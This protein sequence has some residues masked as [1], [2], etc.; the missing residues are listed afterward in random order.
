MELLIRIVDK[1]NPTSAE[2]DSKCM[3][4][5]DVIAI[6]PGGSDWGVQEILNPEWRIIRVPGLSQAEIDALLAPELPPTLDEEYP[7]LR[8][9]A[10]KLDLDALDIKEN[11]DIKKV[12]VAKDPKNKEDIKAMA[13]DANVKLTSVQDTKVVKVPL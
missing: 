12:K 7:L 9:R 13:I 10:M 2:L 4:A 1:V 3:K 5:G 8:K 6:K 11:G